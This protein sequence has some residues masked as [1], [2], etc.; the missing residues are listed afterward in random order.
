M[1]LKRLCSEWQSLL[2][3]FHGVFT[4]GGWARFAQ[5]VTGTVLCSE[6]HTITQILTGLGLEDQWRNVE[7]FAEYGAW[8][9][10]AVERQLMRLVEQEHPPRWGR[11]HPVAIDDTKEH[12]TS[13]DVWGTCTFHESAARSPNRATTVLRTIGSS[14][15]ISSPGKP[16]TYMPTASRLYCRK[17]QLPGGEM[18][19]TKTALAV[20][21]LRGDRRGVG[22]PDFG[23]V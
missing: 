7:H 14:W 10:E 8:D 19:R 3:N 22:R 16:W 6:E 2:E 5:W 17:K 1:M 23:R 13:A 15:A 9:R 12:R 11:Y 18:F 21:M 4:L 20:E